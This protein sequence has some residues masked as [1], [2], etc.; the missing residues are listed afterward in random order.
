MKL[1]VNKDYGVLFGWKIWKIMDKPPKTKFMV[2]FNKTFDFN[3]SDRPDR[4]WWIFQ[5]FTKASSFLVL[6]KVYGSKIWDCFFYI[7]SRKYLKAKVEE[8]IKQFNF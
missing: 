1:F 7:T 3:F 8:I 5:T 6:M 4:S 2:K